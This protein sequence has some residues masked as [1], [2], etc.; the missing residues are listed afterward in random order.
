MSLASSVPVQ[1]T[2][3]S[4]DFHYGG[5]T[6]LPPGDTESNRDTLALVLRT[7]AYTM[8]IAQ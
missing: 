8:V 1:S 6:G 4:I 3:T 2:G 7:R 5:V